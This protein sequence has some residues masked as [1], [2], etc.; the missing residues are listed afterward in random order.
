MYEPLD[1][2]E[3]IERAHREYIPMGYIDHTN[4]FVKSVS[5]KKLFGK[6]FLLRISVEI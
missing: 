3:R 2:N 4:Q 1:I 5:V 6:L